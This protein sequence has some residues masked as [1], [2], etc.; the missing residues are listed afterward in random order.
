MSMDT[1]A[2]RLLVHAR[3]ALA[4]DIVEFDLR[5]PDG[6][7]LPPFAAGSHIS[8]R[9]PSGRVN[10]YSL[11]NCPTETHRYVIAVQRDAEGAGGSVSMVDQ[12]DTGAVLDVVRPDNAFEL[13]PAGSEYLFVAGGIGITPI[14]AMIQSLHAAGIERFRLVYLTRHP[15]TTAYREEI[16]NSAWHDRALIHHTNGDAARRYDLWP[17]L[18]RQGGRQ[19]YCCGPRRLMEEVRAMTGHWSGGTVHFESFGVDETLFSPNRPFVAH[20]QR[21]ALDVPVA[22]DQ[23]LLQALDAQGVH[24]PCSCESGTCGTC[25]TTLIS[26]EVEHRDMVLDEGEQASNIMVCVSRGLGGRI[27]LDL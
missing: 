15:E 13:R 11:C 26:G 6:A 8:V 18:E 4:Q 22:V 27:V 21:Q 2:L 25:R 14:Y 20:L 3:R 17:L 16:S 19:L 1:P 5:L 23:T 24:V 7:P 12:A 9:T 10:K